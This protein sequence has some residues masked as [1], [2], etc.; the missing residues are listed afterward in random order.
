MEQIVVIILAILCLLLCGAMYFGWLRLNE[1]ETKILANESNIVG[2]QRLFSQQGGQQRPINVQSEMDDL[3]EILRSRTE[4]IIESMPELDDDE[5]ERGGGDDEDEDDEQSEDGDD[6]EDDEQSEENDD[7]GEENDDDGDDDAEETQSK[8]KSTNLENLFS[9]PNDD[10]NSSLPSKPADTLND[11]NID[12][13]VGGP[14]SNKPRNKRTP[15]DPPSLYEE[16][17]VKESENDGNNYEVK[18][19]KGGNKRWFKV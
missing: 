13:S 10:D 18:L 17:F 6:D 8:D 12:F 5:D 2:I 16:G 9:S 14:A 19:D 4:K 1:L 11:L 15:N 7:D 3:Q